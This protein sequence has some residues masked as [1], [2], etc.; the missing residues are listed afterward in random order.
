MPLRQKALAILLSVGLIILIFELVRRRKL[1]EEYSWLW[2]LTGVVVFVLAIWH[3]LLLSISRLLGIALPA[4]T[5]FL[6]GVFFSH[7]DQSVFFGK[8]FNSC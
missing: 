3:N 7:T 6:F 4:S 1:R 8:D 2:M 5:I